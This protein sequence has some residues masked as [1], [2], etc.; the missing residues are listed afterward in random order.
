[1][2]IL[3]YNRNNHVTLSCFFLISIISANFLKENKF[4]TSK[5]T[6]NIAIYL[7]RWAKSSFIEMSLL[8]IQSSTR[9][10]L[11][12]AFPSWK[13]RGES[14]PELPWEQIWGLSKVPLCETR[15]C[16]TRDQQNPARAGDPLGT[17]RT[18]LYIHIATET[19]SRFNVKSSVLSVCDT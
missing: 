7:A 11:L 9:Y 4:S 8:S 6:K 12:K 5:C 2:N 3:I 18:I 13:Q 17:W 14:V 15:L 16:E 1:M 19:S 10:I